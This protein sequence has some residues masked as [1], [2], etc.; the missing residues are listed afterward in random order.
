MMEG[1]REGE[2]DG[3]TLNAYLLMGTSVFEVSVA[4]LAEHLHH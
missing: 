2:T 4:N 3:F 1:W